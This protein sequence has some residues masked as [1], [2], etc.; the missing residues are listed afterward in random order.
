[1]GACADTKGTNRHPCFDKEAAA[2]FGRIHLPVAPRCNIQ[3]IY[4]NRREDCVNESRPGVTSKVMSP[5]EAVERLQAMLKVE[6]RISVAAIAGPGDPLAN[7]EATFETLERVKRAAP[8]ML[9]CLSTNGLGLTPENVQRIADAGVTHVTVTV[10]AV[11]PDIGAKLYA[12][13]REERVWFGRKGAELLL[14]RQREG[15]KRLAEAGL[16]VKINTVV[17]PGM[18]EN[19]VGEI[20]REMASLGATLHNCLAVVPA[21][22]TPIAHVAQ[23][24]LREMNRVRAL[25]GEHMRQMGHCARCRADAVGMLGHDRSLEFAPSYMQEDVVA[26]EGA[27]RP[28]VAVATMEGVLVNMHLGVADHVQIWAQEDDGFRQ[29]E[30]RPCP[31]AGTEG[32]WNE[33]GR[34][35]SD[36]RAVLVAAA[37]ESPRKA[38]EARGVL[39]LEMEGLIDDCLEKVFRGTEIATYLENRRNVGKEC[40][41]GKVREKVSGQGGC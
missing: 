38:L 39:A 10:N 5:V 24:T 6:P 29:V 34:S 36:C 14:E 18:N 22:G 28:Y 16:V 15:V 31:S 20:A 7:P 17:V 21:K 11:D 40:G 26:W 3:C 27:S 32:R 30:D 25:S 9:L 33:L 2:S 19:H 12:R 23:P 35:L 13:V 37:G 8:D 4:C 1:M 41:C